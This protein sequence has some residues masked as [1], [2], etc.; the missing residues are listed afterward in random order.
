MKT[1][2]EGPRCEGRSKWVQRGMGFDNTATPAVSTPPCSVPSHSPSKGAK[3][4]HSLTK[5]TSKQSTFSQLLIGLASSLYSLPHFF[6][7]HFIGAVF[8]LSG[9]EIRTS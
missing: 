9:T 4:P 6:P 8:G 5:P 2:T 7:F 1:E 3:S